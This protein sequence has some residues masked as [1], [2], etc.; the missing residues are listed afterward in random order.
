[1]PLS[2]KFRFIVLLLVLGSVA[3]CDQASKHLARAELGPFGFVQLPGGLGEL[4][5]AE[6]PGSFLS[7]GDSLPAPWRLALL[8]VAVA[9]GLF[10]LLAYLA[11]SPKVRRSP[12]LGLALIWAGGMSN[13]FDRVTRQGLVTDF[14]FIRVGPFHTGVF[15]PADVM[16]MLGVA[17]LVFDQ[18][19]QRKRN[20]LN[21]G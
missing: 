6:N 7:L 5:I 21:P 17:A 9:V 18:W 3:G 12:F 16:I 13:L 10:G 4:R 11:F 14:V 1:M 8:T 15:N 20:A 19:N 2:H